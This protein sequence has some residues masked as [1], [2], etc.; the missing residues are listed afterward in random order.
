[1][2]GLM[3]P[4]P[5]GLPLMPRQRAYTHTHTHT[6][7]QRSAFGPASTRASCS[8]RLHPR[9]RS[10]AAPAADGRSGPLYRS[11]SSLELEPTGGGGG[12][13]LRRE[14]G[15]HGSIDAIG[16]E[17]AFAVLT[18]F[19]SLDPEL[20]AARDA[21]SAD[22][23]PRQRSR[24]QRLWDRDRRA[25]RKAGGAEQSLF[26]KLRGGS[27][28]DSQRLS[29]PETSRSTDSLDG[30]ARQEERRRR[31]ALV[32]YDCQ[33]LRVSLA[34]AARR[35]T[36][37]DERHNRATGA[38]AASQPASRSADE[39]SEDEEHG[40][41]RSNDLVQSCPFF[42]N[43]VGGE[44][45]RT[46]QLAPSGGRRRR[47]AARPDLHCHRAPATCGL[48]VL[49]QPAGIT[50]WPAHVC[51]FSRHGMAIEHSNVGSYYYKDF[52][53]GREHENW[54]GTD[55]SLGPVAVSIRRD[56]L[57]E[58]GPRAAAAG[59][60]RDHTCY[61][62]IVRSSELPTLRGLIL[63]ESLFP[64]IKP[65]EKLKRLPVR[66]ILDHVAPE[67]QYN[68]LRLAVAEPRTEDYLMKLD[69]QYI[70]NRYK[71][72]IMYCRAGQSTEEEMY[73]N[74][75][76]GPALDEFL[77][78]LGQRVRLKGFDKYKAGLDNKTDST[79]E[80]SVYVKHQGNEIMFHVSTLLQYSPNNRQQLLRKRYIGNDI[81]TIVFQEPGALPF[82]PK[83]IRSQFQHVFIV[84]R[85]LNPCSE[86]TQ[87]SV[88]VNRFRD[89][90]AF[91]PPIPESA[92][93]SKSQA[94]A[95]FLYAKVIN[96]ENAAYH[97]EKFM[98]M[99]KRT[100]NEYLKDLA[101]NYLTEQT[102]DPPQKFSIMSFGSRKK[103]RPRPRFRP[104]AVQRGAIC[105][106][107]VADEQSSVRQVDCVLG[108]SADSVVLI[109]ERTDRLLFA[110]PAASVLG[111]T[112]QGTSLRVYY[113][114][115]ECVVL[116][117]Q[118]PQDTEEL[119][120]MAA[121]LAA[122][123]AG[124]DSQELVLRRNQLGQLGF[125]VQSDGLVTE[126]E[127]GGPA[128]QAGLRQ[129]ARIVEICRVP[130]CSASY[131]QMV[132]LL[133]TSVPVSLVVLPPGADGAPRRGC[134]LPSCGA[135]AP[136]PEPG[137]RAGSPPP[138]VVSSGYG[139]GGSGRSA[140]AAGSLEAGG[141]LSSS[142]S[143][144]TERWADE[145]EPPPP[146]LP[147][148]HRQR[149][150]AARSLD[151]QTSNYAAPAGLQPRAL[152]TL[153]ERRG[154]Q[155]T[156]AYIELASMNCG[157]LM[158]AKNDNSKSTYLTDSDVEIYIPGQRT[159]TATQD[160]RAGHRGSPAAPAP[161]QAAAGA[162]AAPGRSSGGG[163][164]DPTAAGGRRTS[165]AGYSTLEQRHRGAPRE[166]GDQ[167]HRGAPREEGEQ[168]LRG[169]SR[170][171]ADQR[172]RGTPRDQGEQRLR[173][174]PRDPAP[175]QPAR[176]QAASRQA[177][178]RSQ[179]SGHS[180][181]SVR[182]KRPGGP[183][184]RRIA[185]S[186]SS[187]DLSAGRL[188]SAHLSHAESDQCLSGRSA[189][190]LLPARLGHSRSSSQLGGS[191]QSLESAEPAGRRCA[192]ASRSEDEL[193]AHSLSP[194]ARRRL[195]ADTSTPSSGSGRSQAGSPRGAAPAGR[196]ASSGPYLAAGPAQPAETD[197]L[198]T[199]ARPAHVLDASPE[200]DGPQMDWQTLV[201]TATRAVLTQRPAAGSRTPPGD[202]ASPVAPAAAAAPAPAAGSAASAAPPSPSDELRSRL[203][204]LENELVNEQTRRELLQSQVQKLSSDNQRLQEESRQ[205]ARQL[206]K[207]TQWFLDNVEKP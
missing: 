180:G 202:T 176:Q 95:E 39:L 66:D 204:T 20:A 9:Q 46:L 196:R 73:N 108:I 72:G 64:L 58:S 23:S 161:A 74:E 104:D 156:F 1:M 53:H 51:P 42:R 155:E 158:E 166:E 125:H 16:G 110:A 142:S 126:V 98:T 182:T 192:P 136:E 112:L 190:R 134:L 4:P 143:G 25:S 87:Y 57:Q 60:G 29:E 102:L 47:A 177:A 197:V 184:P 117:P 103:D 34:A 195:R 107:V 76:S 85:A 145:A 157:I 91:G 133:K 151:G 70:F 178:G 183:G 7:L 130:V 36:R 13:A 189:P 200:S 147:A 27:V 22:A 14:F 35:R 163:P 168:R 131:D 115:G 120:E 12:G 48:S 199:T 86:N 8:E 191:H 54:V 3:M 114:Q 49:E 203:T 50:H 28:K 6:R 62:V 165:G 2:D 65:S 17:A 135:P 61:R 150:P 100:R 122:V 63:E 111:W 21:D 55:D 83:H 174:A 71:V 116:R 194:A 78:M 201:D 149:L 160:G 31:R 30:E 121:R 119:A 5:A 132:D 148:R 44:R 127:G 124:C 38:S 188:S 75:Q 118:T 206:R 37:L 40:D 101:T 170:E 26:R 69:E 41:D 94:F 79:G 154:R 141:T 19:R 80:Y 52:F 186:R 10:R 139:T 77:G 123:T 68:C 207:F 32:H 93:F 59:E 144:S 172:L 45:D 185:N 92:T 15:S 109:E 167:R 82:T 162:S 187:T 146:P 11:N 56:W 89:V 96:A 137:R 43:E 175:G 129:G 128:W 97:S 24:L 159:S 88:A 105:W 164:S 179:P 193:S 84:V 140:L 106:Q 67:L 113:H 171:E 205:A 153:Q 198:L 18:E 99:A 181:G 173:G 33:S 169:P 138:S 152:E 90:P 81:V